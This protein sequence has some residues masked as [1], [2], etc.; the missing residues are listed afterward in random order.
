V[1]VR[2]RAIIVTNSAPMKIIRN[3]TARARTT[4]WPGWDDERRTTND[5]RRTT[6]DERRMTNAES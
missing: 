5:E 1:R 6:N 4:D 2:L 3:I